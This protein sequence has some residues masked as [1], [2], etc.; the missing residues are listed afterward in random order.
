MVTIPDS[1]KDL[2]NAPVVTLATQASSGH[3]QVT[4]VWFLN[5]EDG[6]VRISLNTARQKVKNLQKNGKCTL[7]FMDPTSPYRTLEVRGDAEVTPD[8]DYTF[9]TKLGQKYGG[10]NLKER[11]K[12]G[13]T[14]VVISVKPTKVNVW[15]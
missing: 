2:L 6:V 13:E 5:D 3:P 12:P 10:A 11:D 7:F 8:D 15:G 4:A 9:A 1:H 14:R